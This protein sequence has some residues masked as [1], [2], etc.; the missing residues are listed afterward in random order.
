MSLVDE[1]KVP[2]LV[3]RNEPIVDVVER[4]IELLRQPPG[5]L[6]GLQQLR[7][8]LQCSPDRPDRTVR[9]PYGLAD[10]AHP[11]A[12]SRRGDDA[13]RLVERPAVQGA[14]VERVL[15][16]LSVFGDEISQTFFEGGTEARRF[17]V[18]L[19]GHGRPL[20]LSLLEV[21]DPAAQPRRSSRHAQQVRRF[22]R[23]QLGELQLRAILAGS[24]GMAGL[25]IAVDHGLP[26][27]DDEFQFAA[28]RDDAVLDG[29]DVRRA[30]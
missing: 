18:D 28:G 25:A 12:S 4:L 5:T 9:V 2:I 19:R 10:H 29:A 6:A 22:L 14:E 7:Y 15:H 8:V 26:P 13:Q 11:D 3:D 30:E 1:G 16:L 17:V 20:E 23:L 27:L 24:D 21:G